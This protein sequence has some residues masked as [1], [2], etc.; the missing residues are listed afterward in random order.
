MKARIIF[1]STIILIIWTLCILGLYTHNT[2]YGILVLILNIIFA[3]LMIE[4][5]K[6]R[7]NR[8]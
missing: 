8:K 3:V 6:Y 4:F 5:K 2:F 7:R 1:Y